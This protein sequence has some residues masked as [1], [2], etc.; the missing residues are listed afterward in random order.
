[1]QLA[2]RADATKFQG[3]Q[4]VCHENSRRDATGIESTC[5]RTSHDEAEVSTFDVLVQ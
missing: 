1:M 3:Q 2:S 5:G 4:T